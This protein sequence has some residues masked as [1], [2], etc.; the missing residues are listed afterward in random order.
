MSAQ[1]KFLFFLIIASAIFLFSPRVVLAKRTVTINSYKDTLIDEEQFDVSVDIDGFTD[2]KTIYFKGAFV[3]SSSTNYF[4]YTLKNGTWIKNSKTAIEQFEAIIGNWNQSLAVKPDLS[5]TGFTGTGDY[6]FKVGFYYYT[7]TDNLSLVNWSNTVTITINQSLPTPTPT[8]SPTPATS[9]TIVSYP[10]G[11]ILSEFM[12]NPDGGSEW[13]EIKNTSSSEAILTDWKID[14]I[15]DGGGSPRSFSATVSSGGY[16]K[17]EISGWLLNN[18]GDEVRLLYSDDSLV[19]KASYSYSNK[20]VSWIKTDATWCESENPTPGS[21]NSSCR[22]QPN[23]TSPSPT[24]TST[25]TPSPGLRA[26]ELAATLSG[27]VLAEENSPQGIYLLGSPTPS[28]EVSGEKTSKSRTLAKI[29]L[30]TGLVF[31]FGAALSLWYNFDRNYRV[32]RS[33]EV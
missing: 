8:S 5:D 27:E 16:Y 15:A 14:D 13:V 6:N 24:P 25:P 10:T 4:G 2:G 21:A 7:S 28:P 17:V 22:S 9:P 30:I 31:L 29:F 33:D 12:P 18:S 23:S 32:K 3:A 26:V 1:R 19:D 20:G 11:I